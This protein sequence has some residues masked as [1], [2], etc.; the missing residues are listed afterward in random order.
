MLLFQLVDVFIF[1]K[2]PI[3]QIRAQKLDEITGQGAKD[4]LDTC[5]KTSSGD[6]VCHFFGLDTQTEM[7]E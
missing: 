1:V 3:N 6:D 5:V 4:V 7:S 2:S